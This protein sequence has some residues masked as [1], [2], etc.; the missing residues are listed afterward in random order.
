MT[1]PGMINR[2]NNHKKGVTMRKTILFALLF[3]V[4]GTMA[5][6]DKT[7][8]PDYRISGSAQY[9]IKTIVGQAVTAFRV[10]HARSYLLSNIPVPKSVTLDSGKM[11]AGITVTFT[12]VNAGRPDFDSPIQIDVAATLKAGTYPV[13][14]K[15]TSAG[16]PDKKATTHAVKVFGPADGGAYVEVFPSEIHIKPGETKTV[17]ARVH[18]IP[19][20]AGMA[21]VT[22]PGAGTTLPNGVTVAGKKQFNVMLNAANPSRDVQFLLQAAENA[23]GISITEAEVSTGAGA[24]AKTDIAPVIIVVPL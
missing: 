7:V 24:A 1:K 19:P 18:Q 9:E 8:Q 5:C 2:L 3:L 22:F 13:N 4:F 11:A 10:V 20:F 23:S 17:T 16:I 21:T 12:G 6:Q 14:I 15:G